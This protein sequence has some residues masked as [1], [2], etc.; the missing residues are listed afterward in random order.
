MQGTQF[1]LLLGNW[2][3]TSCR[4]IKPSCH[5]YRSLHTFK[6]THLNYWACVLQLLKPTCLEPVLHNKRNHHNEACAPQLESSP[7]LPQLEKSPSPGKATHTQHSQKEIQKKFLNKIN[8]LTSHFR[9][10]KRQQIK[11][12]ILRKK[13]IIKS[14]NWWKRKC[15]I[16]KINKPNNWLNRKMNKIG[17]YL[18]RLMKQKRRYKL[19]IVG[20]KERTPL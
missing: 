5:N 20:M 8:G 1:S 15:T 4:T 16:L 2:D 17:K 18:D 14:R 7:H 3:P 13:E 19:T 6:L 9:K 11:W 12:K 10:W